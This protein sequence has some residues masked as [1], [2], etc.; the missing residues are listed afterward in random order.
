MKKVYIVIG[1]IALAFLLATPLSAKE[2]TPI[3][4]SF[5]GDAKQFVLFQGD[6]TSTAFE[7]MMPG[8]QRT[9]QFIVRN[10]SYEKMKFY[11]R[12]SQAGMLHTDGSS[13]RIV[14]DIN[15]NNEKETFFSGR[16]G[17]VQDKGKENLEEDYLLKTLTKGESTTIDMSIKIDGTSMDNT[18][19][20]NIGHLGLVFSVEVD[21]G[22]PVTEVIKKIPVVNQIPGVVTGDYTTLSWLMAGIVMSAI[23]I[24]IVL[25]KGKKEEENEK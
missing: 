13:N 3:G 10:D 11:V 23:V 12:A 5:E 20:G 15:F 17:S 22:N 25:K 4:V 16:V 2:A 18:Y 1:S 7:D 21:T 24:I 8:E 6:T 19:Q 9:Q 14:Y